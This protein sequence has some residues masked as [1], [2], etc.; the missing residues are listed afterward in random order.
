[1]MMSKQMKTMIIAVILVAA[2]SLSGFCQTPT[3]LK[4]V[5]ESVAEFSDNLAKS[6]G[7]NSALGL[8]WSDAYIGK[9]IPSIPPHFGFGGMFGITT[10]NMPA[11]KTLAGYFGYSM[12]FDTD[13]MILPAYAVEARSGGLFLPFDV[14]FKFGYLAPVELWG[15]NLKVNYL[16]VGGDIR[17]ALLDKP[18]LPKIS[19]GVGINHLKGGLG[20]KV[21]SPVDFSYGTEKITVDAPDIGLKWETTSLDFKAQASF[22]LLVLTPYIGIGGGYAWSKAGY[23]VTSRITATGG[24][25]LDP[26]AINT[27]LREQGVDTVDV[28]TAG[29]SSIIDNNAAHCRLFGGISFNIAVIKIDVTGLYNLIDSNFGGSLGLRLQL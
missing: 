11:I 9:L 12:P 1:M 15:T 16:L 17:Y 29:I 4:K 27:Y 20:A 6:L 24:G 25:T 26:A 19:I 8:N 2:V 22:S 28:N 10:M 7:F 21:G 23:E 5:Q 13:K 18:I 14:G 3:D